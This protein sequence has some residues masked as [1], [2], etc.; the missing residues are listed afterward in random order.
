[1]GYKHFVVL[2]GIDRG[3]VFLADPAHGNL[4]MSTGRFVS[5]WDGIVF[6]LTRGPQHPSPPRAGAPRITPTGAPISGHAV[7]F[8]TAR[9]GPRTDATFWKNVAHTGE[10][11][12]FGFPTHP[13][14]VRHVIGC[15]LANDGH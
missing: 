10:T 3:R 13:H 5:E 2:R 12:Q 4:R 9:K 8:V 1:L 15:K 6:V 14:M 7:C 11:A